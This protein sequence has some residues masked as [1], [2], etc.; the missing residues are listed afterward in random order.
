MGEVGPG[1]LQIFYNPHPKAFVTESKVTEKKA[2]QASRKA[3]RQAEPEGQQGPVVRRLRNGL[4]FHLA[5]DLTGNPL[6][7]QQYG[8]IA[9][10]DPYAEEIHDWA[11][12]AR[13]LFHQR[14]KD[15]QEEVKRAASLGSNV[16]LPRGEERD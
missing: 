12:E 13:R 5:S 14:R 11:P 8:V 15:V 4:L 3:A 16:G 2:A 6:M 10:I 1:P 9:N 7:A